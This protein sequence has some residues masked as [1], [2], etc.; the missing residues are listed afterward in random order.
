LA[1]L[2]SGHAYHFGGA[3]AD[4][5]LAVH[6]YG[7]PEYSGTHALFRERIVQGA[8]DFR[9][10]AADTRVV[11]HSS[12]LV[13]GIAGDP[14]AIGYVGVGF[15]NDTVKVVG[16][17]VDDTA[18]YS[19]PNDE[20]ITDGS[21]P[22]ARP[23]LF[24]V[25]ANPSAEVRDFVAFVQSDAGRQIV[26]QTGFVPAEAPTSD[27]RVAPV[28]ASSNPAESPR[29]VRVQFR[30]S[31]T[32]IDAKGEQSLRDLAVEMKQSSLRALI[33]GNSDTAGNQRSSHDLAL[34][35]AHGVAGVLRDAGV[36]ERAIEVRSA[37][38]TQPVASNADPE[39]RDQNRR[40]DIY[41][42]HPDQP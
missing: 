17:S 29:I 30:R 25:R 8:T 7:R 10:F 24:Y 32:Y 15:V 42:L 3:G 41:L 18:P 22:I 9:G 34:V 4:E 19:R 21:Y 11:E 20:T 5:S 26:A 16:V 39:G 38:A 27:P 6:R 40:V 33:V 36:D 23:L 14:A 31:S 2:Y 37:G 12:G 35:R 28:A 1:A 13:A